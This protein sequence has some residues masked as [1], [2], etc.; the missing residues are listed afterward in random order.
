MSNDAPAH[1]ALHPG[2][3]MIAAPV[4]SEPALEHT[5]PPLDPRP[6]PPGPAEPAL[7]FMGPSLRRCRSR[8][9]QRDVLHPG[10]LGRPL[11]RCAMEASVPG[12]AV[13]GPGELRPVMRQTVTPLRR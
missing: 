2:S 12:E 7:A 11:V 4:Q 3:A 8:F 9:R 1:P 10:F 13:R 6:E 5:D